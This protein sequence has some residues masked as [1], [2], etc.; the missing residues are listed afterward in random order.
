MD[1]KQEKRILVVAESNDT[2]EL[3]KIMLAS[4]GYTSTICTEVNRLFEILTHVNPHL[5]VWHLNPLFFETTLEI[6]AKIR[7]TYKG[8]T[9][10][11]ILLSVPT[12]WSNSRIES[13]V[14]GILEFLMEPEYFVRVV[15]DLLQKS[16]EL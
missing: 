15:E 14:D 3:Y 11:A 2:G 4:G 1:S 9:S 8:N 6:L 13:I 12:D 7:Q 10:P 16:N 5:V